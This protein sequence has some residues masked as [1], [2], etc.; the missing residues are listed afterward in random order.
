MHEACFDADK[1]CRPNAEADVG[2]RDVVCLRNIAV[3]AWLH[4]EMR[5]GEAQPE[6]PAA[7][8]DVPRFTGTGEVWRRALLRVFGAVQLPPRRH[9]L[10]ARRRGGDEDHAAC[11]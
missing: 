6:T 8:C 10:R 1:L 5:R 4:C 7:E 9:A 11:R 2:L 3:L